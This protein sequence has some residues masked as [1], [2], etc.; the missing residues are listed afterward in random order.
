MRILVVSD[1]LSP[2]HAGP[3]GITWW[4]TN[5]LFARGHDVAVALPEPRGVPAEAPP[6]PPF[7][8]RFP[9]RW[10]HPEAAVVAERRLLGGPG[11]LPAVQKDLLALV[12][13]STDPEAVDLHQID[14]VIGIGTASPHLRG[15]LRVAAGRVGTAV[16][17]HPGDLD[18]LRVPVIR[19]ELR[20]HPLTTHWSGFAA[21]ASAITD[22][23][24][25]VAPPPGA[26]TT[27]DGTATATGEQAPRARRPPALLW[28]RTARGPVPRS[29]DSW[30]AA[31]G[32]DITVCGE[33][34]DLHHED[35]LDLTSG[36]AG[37]RLD[38][39]LTDADVV[40]IEPGDAGDLPAVAMRA[41]RPLIAYRGSS[42]TDD[43]A[44]SGAGWVVDDEEALG[45]ALAA[46]RDEW[47]RR[48]AAGPCC[49][50]HHRNWDNA[51]LVYERLLGASRPVVSAS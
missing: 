36:I 47:E 1:E 26:P 18:R 16:H 19:R 25:E 12:G 31:T 3:A 32:A 21:L 40:V 17:L 41:G 13:P 45:A 11:L 4:L 22:R 7:V 23:P 8:Q 39:V 38:R 48:G 9:A 44:V 30:R 46:G 20:P 49:V 35:Y 43:L 10:P 14:G 29:L 37:H 50:A 5:G 15:F 51:I 24:V 2:A 34:A 28:I 27:E 42:A 33:I 6:D